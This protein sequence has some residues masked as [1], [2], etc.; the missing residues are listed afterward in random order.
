M[1]A[2]ARRIFPTTRLS[3]IPPGSLLSGFW[4]SALLSSWRVVAETRPTR[5]RRHPVPIVA[6]PTLAVFAPLTVRSRRTTRY[7]R[8]VAIVTTVDAPGAAFKTV[9][10]GLRLLKFHPC[11][12]HLTTT[13]DFVIVQLLTRQT[14]R[15]STIVPPPGAT[16]P[17][18]P[19][20]SAAWAASKAAVS[21]V[22]PSHLAPKSET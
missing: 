7:V 21:S 5:S 20:G 1:L 8:I 6:T 18:A 17:G 9:A 4:A 16:S 11:P 2:L 10:A 13:A 14:P 19:T 3:K 22:A 12:I 15:G